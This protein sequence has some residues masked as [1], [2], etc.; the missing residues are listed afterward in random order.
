MDGD[1]ICHPRRLETQAAYLQAHP[2]AGLVACGF[3]HFPRQSLRRG[4]LAY[5]GWQNSLV[6]HDRITRDLFVESPFVHP[7][8]MTRRGLVTQLGGYRDQGW[9]EDYD[10]WLRMA[11]AGTRFARLDATLFFW[12]D[13]PERATRT[14]DAYTPQAMRRCK[15]H[16]LRGGLLNETREV[17]LAGAG[18][19]ARAWQRLLAAE[20]VAVSNW[21]DIDPR[22]VGTT[23][24]GAPVLRPEELQLAGRKMLVAIG[25]RG[26]REQF[27]Q[28]AAGLGWQEGVDFVSVA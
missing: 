1:D 22:K 21:L 5:E 18:Q 20:G 27:R 16:H 12:R 28:T 15:F 6:D 4:M 25:L 11:A 9:P 24:H 13:H 10:L 7:G 23:L 8:I 19:E 26:A 17:V 2:D 14:M 3:R